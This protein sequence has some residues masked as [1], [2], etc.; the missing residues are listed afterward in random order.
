MNEIMAI[1]GGT[2]RRIL[3]M[4]V[5][6]F[7]ILCV[8]ILIGSAYNYDILSMGMHKQLMV[9]VSLVLNTI[10]AILIAVSI[11]F[12]IPK[13]L[14]EGVAST[15]LSKPL[16]RTQY[17]VGK[18]VGIIV[19]GLVIT[20][21]ITLGFMFVFSTAFGEVTSSMIKGHILIM[22]SVIPMSAIAVLFSVFIPD[23]LAATATVV[24]IWLAHATAS[25]SG[26][27]LLYGGILPDLNL[28]NLR[29]EAVYGGISS[30]YILVALVWGIVF[31]VFATTLA[32]LI[33]SNKDLK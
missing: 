1:A 23:F 31:S 28:Y 8:L 30:G 10:A 6:Y 24:A 7:L 21:L 3:R 26:V 15:L 19:T 2:W 11:T 16:G 14:K 18:L 32:S 5:V 27:K 9:D 20:G 33:F 29:A 12:E 22:A 13:E 4:R 25:L 17:L